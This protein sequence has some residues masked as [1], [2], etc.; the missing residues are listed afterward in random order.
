MNVLHSFGIRGAVA[1]GMVAAAVIFAAHPSTQG[2]QSRQTVLIDGHE[3]AAGEVIVKLKSPLSASTRVQLEQQV[4]ADQS[5]PVGSSMRRMR[6][7][8]FDVPTLLAFLRTHPDVAFAEPNYVL[9]ATAE[10]NDPYFPFLWGLRNVGQTIAVPGVSGAD[11]HA[12]S[13]WDLSTGSRANVVAVI[14]TGI[15]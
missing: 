14:D 6:S 10:P 15:D 12:T 4:D 9:R 5:E 1:A 2:R 3:A 8:R 13:A 7:R 11:I